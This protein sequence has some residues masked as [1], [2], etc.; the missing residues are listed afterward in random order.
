MVDEGE[1]A[2]EMRVRAGFEELKLELE[3]YFEAR[4]TVRSY[5]CSVIWVVS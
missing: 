5:L 1:K 3:L 2:P 4:V